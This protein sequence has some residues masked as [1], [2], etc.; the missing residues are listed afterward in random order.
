MELTINLPANNKNLQKYIVVVE[1]IYKKYLLNID[2]PK[3][4]K[5]NFGSLSD[6][7]DEKLYNYSYRVQ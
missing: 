4:V 6:I 2:I 5:A 1:K 3:L 7:K